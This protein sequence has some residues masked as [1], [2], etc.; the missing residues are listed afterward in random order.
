[1]HNARFLTPPSNGIVGVRNR[2]IRV[3]VDGSD[4]SAPSFFFRQFGVQDEFPSNTG[5]G[6]HSEA[7]SLL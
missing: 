3:I 5:G 4:S 1:M 7:T 6:G 2:A